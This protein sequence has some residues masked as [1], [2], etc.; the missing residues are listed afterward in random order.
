MTKTVE[1]TTSAG[2]IRI[3]LDDAQAPLTVANFLTY[4]NSGDRKSVV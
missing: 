2:A 3:E 1:L 4:V